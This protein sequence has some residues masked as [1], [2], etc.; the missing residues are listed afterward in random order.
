MVVEAERLLVSL[1]LMLL[2]EFPMVKNMI[3]VSTSREKKFCVT[4]Q[5]D[6]NFVRSCATSDAV[7]GMGER[8]NN[9]PPTIKDV[10]DRY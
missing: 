6:N 10:M 3:S 5:M 4:V 7:V 1:L 8:M 9:L 2:V